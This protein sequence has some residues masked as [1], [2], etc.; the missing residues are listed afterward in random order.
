MLGTKKRDYLSKLLE[1][2]EYVAN[3]Y[4]MKCFSAIMLVF[5]VAFIL[6]LL[7]IFVV[8]KRLMIFAFVPSL[9]VYILVYIVTRYISLS[10]RNMKYFIHCSLL[11]VLT[12]AGVFITYHVT[13]ALVFPILCAVLYSSKPFM[14]YVYILTGICTAVSVYGGYYF[15]LCDANMLLLT[16]HSAKAYVSNGQFIL[17][18]INQNPTVSLMLFYVIPRCF[19]F[20]AFM[21]GCS[22]LY[23]IVSG[24]LEK[25]KLTAELEEAK[26]EAEKANRAKSQFLARMSH[27]IRT[28]VNA[29]MGMTEMIIR[30]SKE[31]Q[32]V[33]YAC[34]VKNSSVELL[35]I[36]NEILDS[37]KLESGKMELVCS[38]YEIAHLLGD[39]YNMINIKAKEKGLQLFFDID[40]TIPSGYNGDEKRI[41][42]VLLNLLTNAVK[43]TEYGSVILKCNCR[44]EGEKGI[45]CFSVKDTGIGIRKED[46]SK[47]F[48]SFTRLDEKRNR[49][50]EGT[51]L[52]MSI[53]QQFLDLMGSEL[54]VQS[55]YGRGSEFSFELKQKVV[56]ESELGVFSISQPKKHRQETTQVSFFAPDAKVL[57]VDDNQM[58][59]KVF[60]N[61]LKETGLQIAEADSGE[62]ALALLN[63]GH[64]DAI[65]LDYM[66]PFMDGPETLRAMREKGVGK[67][68]PVIM[69]SAKVISDDG[70]E[71]LQEGF[72]D[73]LAK[74][75]I[76]AEL[77]GMLLKYLPKHLIHSAQV[78]EESL[79]ENMVEEN[80]EIDIEAGMKYCGGDKGLYTE[81]WK[82]FTRLTVFDQLTQ[83]L[84]NDDY[85]GYCTLIHGFK[86]NAYSVGAKT[87]GDMAYEMEKMTRD[88][89]PPETESRQQRLYVLY[90]K[91]CGMTPA[92]DVNH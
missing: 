43:Y 67:D 58:N 40:Q 27:E 38:D 61:L 39:L 22:S 15:G 55:E 66:M 80:P 44:K 72:D 24:T 23:D 85:K 45:L 59:L 62:T 11:L 82:E 10:N 4:T 54:K 5:G 76:P 16:T 56:D 35:D 79:E 78:P 7:G 20:L 18:E 13:L 88:S 92:I 30:E 69:L 33:G 64:Y 89:L 12:I 83:C 17:T 46:M 1:D 53:V 47:L 41:R 70:D 48:D 9:L 84:E 63:N 73:F 74:P 6:D 42:Q 19:I 60:R 57:V 52:G 25:A 29:V 14:R 21:E 3:R 91:I 77:Y 26:E 68:I 36:I 51:G 86:N 50:V 90:Q 49:N 31:E 32:I 37:S 75:I 8:E 2:Q 81:L 28:P 87:L 71:Y 34:D 65:F